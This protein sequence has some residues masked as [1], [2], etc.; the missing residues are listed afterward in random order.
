MQV[1]NQSLSV[2]WN[3]TLT[4]ENVKIFDIG[5]DKH[6]NYPTITLL[7]FDEDKKKKVNFSRN[8]C[9]NFEKKKRNY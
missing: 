5:D 3:E 7:L 9:V 1:I 6:Y 8:L 2:V 4:I